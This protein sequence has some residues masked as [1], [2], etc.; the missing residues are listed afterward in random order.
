MF[1]HNFNL[2]GN[3]NFESN[4]KELRNK[5]TSMLRQSQKKMFNETINSKV[6]DP[7][8]FY[9]N[10][11]KLNIISDKSTKAKINFSAQKLNENFV[12]NN[13]APIDPNF[14]DEKLQNLY[15]NFPPSIHKFSFQPVTE[16]DVVKVA[17]SIKSMSVGCDEI[18]SFVIKSLLFRISTVL[19]HI[20]NVSFE[21][22]IFPENWKK[23]II[24]PIPKVSIPMSPSDFR[25]ISLLPALSKIIE[26][27][28]NIQIVKYLVQHDFLDPYQSAYRKKHSTQTAL[29]K[30]TED[31]Y[32]II[33][34]SEL[35]LLVLLDF[36]KA[37]DTVNH[38]LL[39]A[40]LDILGFENITCDWILSYLSGRKQMVKTDTECSDWCPLQNGVP[41]GSILGPLL[42]TILVSD[43]RRS[44]WNGSYI[45]YAD[46]TNLYWESEV[47][48]INSTI[49]TANQVL[50]KISTYC[51]DTFLRLNEGKC[52]YII[53]GTKP[54]IKKLNTIIQNDVK[55]NDK[56]LERINQ[57]KILGILF[58]EILSWQKQVNLCISKSMGNFFQM[59]RYKNFLDKEAKITLCDSI[60]LSQF[61][62]CDIVYSN[63]DVFLEKKVQK[64]QNICLRFIFNYRMKDKCDLNALRKELKWLNMK[65]RRIAHGLTMIY[66]ILHGLAPNYL[67]DSF[68]LSSEIH[69]INTR[70]ANT[71]IYINKSIK[72]KLH[73]KAYTCY[74]AK[75]YNSI[76]EYIKLSVSVNSFKLKLK[77][78]ILSGKMVLPNN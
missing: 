29:L 66:K 26:K 44:I 8:D 10:A 73:R 42:F 40:K 72:S 27:L 18:N 37:F 67:S 47:D 4:Y 19:V 68:T 71:D 53:F 61:N 20:V 38:K 49:D 31:I 62:Y 50:N 17:K 39:V 30:L 11:K 34:D 48:T 54:G 15:Q 41:Q 24:T 28:A 56:I 46:D 9:K 78:H 74:M 14:L 51:S 77:E 70:R 25:P 3:K 55:I 12:K 16:Q 2:T 6:K 45:T 69:N 75:I 5:V 21:H 1:K 36:S 32:D 13:N 58:D 23:A 63:M 52:K 7:K 64:I 43:M 57:A 33:D 35:T 76:P 59:Y 60:I 65:N 22:G